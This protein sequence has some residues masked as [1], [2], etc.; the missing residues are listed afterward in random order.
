M[1]G[2]ALKSNGCDPNGIVSRKI[3]DAKSRDI[4]DELS[5]NAPDVGEIE[6]PEP[7]EGDEAIDPL[8]D[9]TRTYVEQMDCYKSFQDRP[10]TRRRNGGSS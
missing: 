5:A 6:W 7:A 4:A 9:S 2:T 1:L 8:F 3:I 10:T